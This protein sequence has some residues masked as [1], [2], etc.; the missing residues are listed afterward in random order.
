MKPN[1]P[2]HLL[3]GDA[4]EAALEAAGVP[5]MRCVWREI[6]TAGPLAPDWRV[7]WR[8]ERRMAWLEAHYGIPRGDFVREALMRGGVWTTAMTL[9]VPLAIWSDPDL[10]DQTI[11]MAICWGRVQEKAAKPGQELHYVPLPAGP[12]DA[13]AMQ[14]A[15]QRRETLGAAAIQAAARAWEAYAA[16]DPEALRRWLEEE[17][18]TPQLAAL[19]EALR[20]HLLRFPGADG[21]GIVERE[22]LLAFDEAGD[23]GESP[24]VG[25]EGLSALTLFGRVAPRVPLFWMGDLQFW[26][27]L[28]R[29]AASDPPLVRARS[30]DG[31]DHALP[32]RLP[33]LH[34]DPAGCAGLRYALTRAGRDVLDGVRMA[35]EGVTECERLRL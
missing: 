31:T 19:V 3:N 18:E 30:A 22:T 7:L 33:R 11:L 35:P 5:G 16:A 28:E 29:L 20:F 14:D 13:G 12:P 4:S 17:G 34:D 9:G 24:D 25:A 10:F 15:W 21:L 1:H 6:Y 8:T 32:P 23:F 27:C 2:I 26:R